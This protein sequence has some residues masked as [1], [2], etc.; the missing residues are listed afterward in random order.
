MKHFVLH[1]VLQ[2]KSCQADGYHV[3]NNVLVQEEYLHSSV[4]VIVQVVFLMLFVFDFFSSRR[5]GVELGKS[6]V[7]QESNSG[8]AKH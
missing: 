3:A 8:E 5:L 6:V 4:S 1:V 2:L 7:Y